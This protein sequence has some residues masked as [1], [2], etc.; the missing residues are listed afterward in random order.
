MSIK[1]LTD[2]QKGI[3]EKV[4]K[5][6][7]GYNDYGNEITIIRKNDGKLNIMIGKQMNI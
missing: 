1:N 4:R 3:F 5:N 7:A 2:E 6:Y